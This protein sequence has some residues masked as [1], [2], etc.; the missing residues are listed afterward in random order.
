M[1][2]LWLTFR[3]RFSGA[4]ST[5]VF[6]EYSTTKIQRHFEEFPFVHPTISSKQVPVQQFRHPKCVLHIIRP[7][8]E[9]VILLDEPSASLSLTKLFLPKIRFFKIAMFYNS[10]PNSNLSKPLPSIVNHNFTPQNHHILQLHLRR[11]LTPCALQSKK[12]W[13]KR[14]AVSSTW[15]GACT[16][17]DK[18]GL[19]DAASLDFFA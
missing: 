1:N 6:V 18:P 9:S 19:H 14:S 15:E 13:R 17:H 11:L 12:L 7:D 4:L 2:S 3:S 10:V 8:I 5:F 16:L